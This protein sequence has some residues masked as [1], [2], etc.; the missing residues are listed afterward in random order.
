[1]TQSGR[2]LDFLGRFVSGEPFVCHVILALAV[3][4]AACGRG[5]EHD[6]RPDT[7]GEAAIRFERVPDGPPAPAPDAVAILRPTEA[8]REQVNATLR[9]FIDGD[10]SSAQPLLKKFESLLLLP[11]SKPNAAATFTPTV[12]RGERHESF[13]EIAK[14]GN[15]DLL[16]L[17]DSITDWW[18]LDAN[19]PVFDKYFGHLR[20][21]N[22]GVAGDTTQGVLWA[23]R[24]GEGQGFQPKAVMLLIGVNNIGAFSAPEVAE[25]IGAVVLELRRNFPNAQILLLGLFP[26]SFAGDPIRNKIAEVNQIISILDDRKHV[27]YMDIGNRFLDESGEFLPNVF[28]PDTLHPQTKGY[29]IWAQAVNETLT[30]LLQ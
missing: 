15:I 3:A 22:F 1:M 7:T 14:R 25:G 4:A 30:E 24:N 11:P 20:T 17:G 6:S 26:Y 10:R 8:E 18:R 29:E 13:V 21:A 28:M 2:S 5:P 9:Q 19:K 27:F 23:L 16:L 12:H